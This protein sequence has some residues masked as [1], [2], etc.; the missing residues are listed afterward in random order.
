M[1]R[2]LDRQINLQPV[3]RES[4]ANLFGEIGNFYIHFRRAQSD[5]R[6]STGESA[7]YVRRREKPE[8]STAGLHFCY[9]F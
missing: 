4:D 1:R 5:V 8:F 2:P 6:E 7:R 9:A 3:V